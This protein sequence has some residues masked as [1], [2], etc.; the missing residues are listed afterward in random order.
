MSTWPPSSIHAPGADT[1]RLE[2]VMEGVRVRGK[3]EGVRV[4]VRVSW[5]I[6][7]LS[8]L[9]NVCSVICILFFCET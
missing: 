7:M 3:G 2:E 4:R 8:L 1:H 9:L 6:Q 5:C